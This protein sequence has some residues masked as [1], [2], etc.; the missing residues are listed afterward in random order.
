MSSVDETDKVK[1]GDGLRI[2]REKNICRIGDWAKVF[3]GTGESV[4]GSGSPIA[5]APIASGTEIFGKTFETSVVDASRVLG[6]FC[7]SSNGI[8]NIRVTNDV[9]LQDFAEEFAVAK[10]HVCLM[11]GMFGCMFEGAFISE[12]KSGDVGGRKGFRGTSL[13]VMF[14]VS[15][16]S[17]AV[18]GKETV[19]IAGT[20]EGDTSVRL[21]EVNTIE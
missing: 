4:V 15:R 10:T 16:G 7:E 9:S 14:V 6:E 13:V 12:K 17:P 20:M 19:D 8:S 5:D 18:G 2:V 3:G 1:R 21:F 11:G